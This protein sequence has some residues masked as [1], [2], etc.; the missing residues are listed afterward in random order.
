MGDFGRLKFGVLAAVALAI[1]VL[2]NGCSAV[3]NAANSL[4]CTDF[5][6][7]TDMSAT[8]FVSGNAT[9]NGQWDAFAS[10]AGD[11]SV[12]AGQAF[13]D[14]TAACMGIA[15]DLGDDPAKGA[16]KT[17]DDLLNFW[18]GEAV[19]LIGTALGSASLSVDFQPP[20]CEI[21]VQAQA[22][23]QGHC[24][25]S[26]KCDIKANPPTCTGGTLD[27]DCKGECDAT[28]TAP[29]ID[30]TGSCSGTCTGSCTGSASVAVDCQGKCDGN[31]KAGGASGGTGIQADGSCQ[32]TCDGK[33]TISANATP[34]ACK[35]SCSG[36]CQGNCTATPGQAS[37]QCSGTCKADYTPLSCKGGKLEGGC[38]V[39]ANCQANC[40]AS[41]SAKADCTPPAVKITLNGAAAVDNVIATL[42]KNLPNILV[43]FKARGPDFAGSLGAV[44][45]GGAS[46]TVTDN[47]ACATMIG[48]QIASA[49][50]QFGTA[51]KGAGSVAG[52]CKIQ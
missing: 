17:G 52:A 32:G 18:C 42:E 23:C 46:L 50:D 5:K 22:D 16:G 24:D 14:V 10:A 33:C 35:G 30:C 20:Q 3:S 41:A 38:K 28:A 21:S 37:V 47:A 11:M 25:V 12:V 6:P 2:T 36:S 15:T 1:P 19:S 4:C 45:N 34:V 49:V 44:V 40:N 48:L 51:L 9:V 43:V 27:I 7:G 8:V 26:G 39:D 13:A 31:C 29:T